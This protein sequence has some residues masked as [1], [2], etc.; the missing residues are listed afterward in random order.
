VAAAGDAVERGVI[1][2]RLERRSV[3]SR[4]AAG[5]A[6]NEQVV[7]ANVDT[8]FVVSAFTQDLNPRRLE[9]Y[10]T[11]VWE[12]GAVP[13]VVLNKMDLCADPPAAAA[14]IGQ[15]LPFVDVLAVSALD[16][17]GMATLLPHLRPATTIALV[18]S[19][20]VG[21]STIVNGLLGRDAQ[22][23]AAARDDDDK[24]R[25]TTTARQL[26][27]LPSGALL[28]DTPGMRELQPWTD[29]SAVDGTFEDIA[30][31]AERCQFRDCA[32]ALEPGCAL[33]E[34]IATGSLDEA[35]LDSYRKLLLEAAF[36]ERKR[37]KAVAAQHKRK[38]KQI[39]I[40]QRAQ[41]KARERS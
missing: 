19:S 10:L 20:G 9:R 38:W 23:V 18:G 33:R 40:A 41:Y 12:S 3:I 1:L 17:S 4:R 29:P 27:E 22:R 32:H 7:A 31:L 6:M 2:R 30:A 15:R 36:E 24:G 16:A 8:V 26:I 11:M 21:K 13:V 28:I 39:H 25:H 34:A 14:S 37:D 35:R 5:R